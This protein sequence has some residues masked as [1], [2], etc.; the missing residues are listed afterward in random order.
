MIYKSDALNIDIIDVEVPFSNN[1]LKVLKIMCTGKDTIY[2]SLY[3]HTTTKGLNDLFFGVSKDSYG[4][5]LI[6]R[7]SKLSEM[8]SSGVAYLNESVLGTM[9]DALL[10]RVYNVFNITIPV[11]IAEQYFGI[12]VKN[13]KRFEHYSEV[14]PVNSFTSQ[15]IITGTSKTYQGFKNC[16]YSEGV[17]DYENI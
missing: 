9:Y 17:E 11:P 4:S 14:A 10:M 12:I 5:P 15:Y 7:S 13:F 8:F 3:T 1:I 6:V 2:I 16:I